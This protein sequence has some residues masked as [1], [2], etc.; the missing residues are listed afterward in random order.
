MLRE[1]KVAK[2]ARLATIIQKVADIKCCEKLFSKN[3]RAI[4]VARIHFPKKVASNKCNDE[5]F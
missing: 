2:V 1:E 3:L 5:Q 4:N